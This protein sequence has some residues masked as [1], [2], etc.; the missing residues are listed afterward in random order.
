MHRES[1]RYRQRE[2]NDAALR[3]RLREIAAD[4]PRFG[5]RRMH[6]MLRPEKENERP[7]WIVN[8]KRVY[9]L[10][11]EE[12]LAMR[13]K[14]R[15][16]FRA[17]ARVPLTLP[18]RANQVWTMDFLKDSFASGRKFRTFNLRYGYTRRMAARRFFPT[19]AGNRPDMLRLH[20]DVQL[21]ARLGRKLAAM[22]VAHGHDAQGVRAGLGPDKVQG[23]LL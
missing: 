6:R 21:R 19:A 13:R 11:Q 1:W 10:Y 23:H 2:R 9:R 14:K 22:L 7:K 17:D 3:V 5:Y 20:G 16:R 4:P 8:H 12:G 18:T 15:K